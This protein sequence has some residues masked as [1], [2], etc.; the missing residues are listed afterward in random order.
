LEQ[1]ATPIPKRRRINGTGLETIL[2]FVSVLALILGALA[3][4]LALI[5][6]GWPGLAMFGMIASGAFL[7]WLVLR[8]IA[9]L[10]RL[11]K[12]IAGLEYSGRISGSYFDTV[13]TCSNCGSMLHSDV[14]C[15][16]CGARL[17]KP[18]AEEPEQDGDEP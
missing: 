1:T 6:L 12:R 4:L 7:N 11:Q 14:A 13:P 3:S 5:S 8:S 2:D 9:E 10:I 16:A 15:D 17:L 18:D